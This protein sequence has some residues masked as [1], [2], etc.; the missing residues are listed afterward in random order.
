MTQSR[1]CWLHS[2]SRILSADL[3]CVHFT[4][5]TSVSAI[6][7]PS[8]LNLQLEAPVSSFRDVHVAQSHISRYRPPHQSESSFSNRSPRLARNRNYNITKSPLILS[9]ISHLPILP[10]LLSYANQLN[11][12][13][14]PRTSLLYIRDHVRRIC[15]QREPVATSPPTRER[16]GARPKQ[17]YPRAT[18]GSLGRIRS[19][20]YRR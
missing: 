1:D 5:R 12:Q 3:P 6:I 8:S 13:S 16:A 18:G 10:P 19:H 20:P 15:L 14:Q 11:P 4:S 7:T 2:H 9:I 17:A